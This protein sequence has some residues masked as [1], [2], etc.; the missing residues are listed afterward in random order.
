[1]QQCKCPTCELR[2]IYDTVQ[3]VA[4]DEYG[5]CMNCLVDKRKNFSA[6]HIIRKA[7]IRVELAKDRLHEDDWRKK[8]KNI[9]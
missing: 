3:A 1:M 9:L 5:E 7:T 8:I 4:I 6:Q 2:Y